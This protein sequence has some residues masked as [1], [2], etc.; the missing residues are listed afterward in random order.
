MARS[1]WALV[2]GLTAWTKYMTSDL[3]RTRGL[4]SIDRA[5]KAGQQGCKV[6]HSPVTTVRKQEVNSK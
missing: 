1:A 2:V 6:A 5:G 4:K 3:R